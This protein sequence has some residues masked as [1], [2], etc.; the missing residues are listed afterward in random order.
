MISSLGIERLTGLNRGWTQGQLW[1]SGTLAS[2]GI[3]IGGIEMGASLAR[4]TE[5][6]L[7]YPHVS[8]SKNQFSPGNSDKIPSWEERVKRVFG[9]PTVIHPRICLEPA[10][11]FIPKFHFGVLSTERFLA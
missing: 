2:V 7:T 5:D 1:V 8:W 10:L 11:P 9:I 4:R 3:E 6:L